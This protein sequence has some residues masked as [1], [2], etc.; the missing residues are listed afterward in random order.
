MHIDKRVRDLAARHTAAEL[1]EQITTALAA[2]ATAYDTKVRDLVRA[3]QLAPTL[4]I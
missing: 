4:G 1:A 2:G 3:Y